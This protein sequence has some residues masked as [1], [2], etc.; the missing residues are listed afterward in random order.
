MLIPWN[1]PAVFSLIALSWFVWKYLMPHKKCMFNGGKKH[2][3]PWILGVPNA[4][5]CSA[6]SFMSFWTPFKRMEPGCW[7][8][9]SMVVT[10]DLLVIVQKNIK[11]HTELYIYHKYHKWSSRLLYS[12]GFTSSE[13]LLQI[14][15]YQRLVVWTNPTVE[16]NYI[17]LGII[18]QSIVINNAS[19]PLT[20]FKGSI[21]PL[22]TFDRA[23]WN[24]TSVGKPSN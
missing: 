22:R 7:S 2:D 14:T 8:Q 6:A 4:Q 19:C 16:N 21:L 10:N 3:K 18:I 13:E 11:Q 24:I 23:L 15:L 5:H 20:S 12:Q 17:M 9:S 1:P